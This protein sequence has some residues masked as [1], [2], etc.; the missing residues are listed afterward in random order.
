MLRHLFSFDRINW[1][2]LLGGLGLNFVIATFSSLIGAYYASVEHTAEFYATYGPPLMVLGVFVTCGIAG[3][4]IAKISDDVPIKHA[5]L[6]GLGAAVPYTAAAVLSFNIGL[7]MFA[8]IALA[9]NMNGGMLAMPRP[10][11]RSD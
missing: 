8:V 11:T 3:W 6:S 7:L 9:G 4:I 2:T 5:F 10:R 1:W